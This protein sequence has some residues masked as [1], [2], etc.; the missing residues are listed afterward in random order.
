[1]VVYVYD[2]EWVYLILVLMYVS[3]KLLFVE[4]LVKSDCKLMIF[5][6]SVNV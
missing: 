1:M 5:M 6:D 2:G 4:Y 3:L